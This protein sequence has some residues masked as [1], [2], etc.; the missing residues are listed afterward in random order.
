MWLLTIGNYNGIDSGL[1]MAAS[2]ERVH[3]RIVV[4]FEPGIGS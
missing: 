4:D 1:T 3:V 2:R